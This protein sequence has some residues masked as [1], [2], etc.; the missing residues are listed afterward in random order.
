MISRLLTQGGPFM[1]II[2]I[3]L[4]LSLFFIVRAFIT[5]NKNITQSKKM[6]GLVNESSIL[7]LV[8]GCFASVYSLIDLFDMVEAIGNVRPDLFSAGLKVSMLTVIF[9]LFAFT[10][11]RIGILAYKWTH[12]TETQE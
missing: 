12:K 9:G 1:Y 7:S 4:L 11:G 2:L 5:M 3:T 8:I 6:I 10:I